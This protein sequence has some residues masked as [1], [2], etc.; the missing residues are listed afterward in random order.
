MRIRFACLVLGVL[1]VP[2]P[3]FADSHNWDVQGGFSAGGG[4]STLRGFI[5]ALGLS[6]RQPE[7]EK[8]GGP[9][10]PQRPVLLGL[11][12][13]A[14]VQFGSRDD[15][16]ASVTQVI[17]SAGPRFT[18]EK[19]RESRNSY[20][21]QV[22]FGQVLTNGGELDKNLTTV[23]GAAWD[24]SFGAHNGRTPHPGLGMRLQADRVFSVGKYKGIDSGDNFWRLSASVIYRIPKL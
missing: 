3:A 4:G 8:P 18:F 11:V 12:G 10:P 24:H 6:E 22:T 23:V 17:W 19:D 2:G 9:M 15:G 5:V 16:S 7:P 1:L 13:G 20:H 21:A 14:S